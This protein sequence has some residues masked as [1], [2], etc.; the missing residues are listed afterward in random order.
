M[1]PTL[2]TRNGLPSSSAAACSTFGPTTLAYMYVPRTYVPGPAWNSLVLPNRFPGHTASVMFRSKGWSEW[3]CCGAIAG[4]KATLVVRYPKT[5]FNLPAPRAKSLSHSLIHLLFVCV[6][7]MAAPGDGAEDDKMQKFINKGKG[8]RVVSCRC[9][10]NNVVLH[11]IYRRKFP[12]SRK[13][14]RPARGKGLAVRL[15]ILGL[16][17]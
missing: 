1:W 11:R 5:H 10:S 4:A 3:G 7:A 8:I 15:V 14:G 17:R 2:T 12:F 9:G 13:W 16:C 6:Y